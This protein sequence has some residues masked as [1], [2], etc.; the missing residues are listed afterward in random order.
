MGLSDLR[1]WN[2]EQHFCSLFSTIVLN[3]IKLPYYPHVSGSKKDSYYEILLQIERHHSCTMLRTDLSLQSRSKRL[4]PIR[5][6]A[7]PRWDYLWHFSHDVFWMNPQPE[8]G[9]NGIISIQIEKYYNTMGEKTS[10]W[11][12]WSWWPWWSVCSLHPLNKAYC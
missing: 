6:L 12:A 4:F 10:T 11:E 5:N 7:N 2:F 3:S 8:D 9:E 1:Q